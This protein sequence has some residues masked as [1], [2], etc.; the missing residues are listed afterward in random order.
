MDTPSHL[1]T[2][3]RSNWPATPCIRKAS[4]SAASTGARISPMVISNTTAMVSSTSSRTD[5]SSNR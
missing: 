1:G 2:P 5:S 4:T 3:C